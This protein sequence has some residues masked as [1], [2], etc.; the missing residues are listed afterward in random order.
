[1]A[2]KIPNVGEVLLLEELRAYL[3]TLTLRLFQNDYT[4]VD[5][6]VI[7][8][9]TEATFD[10]YASQSLSDFAAAYLNASNKAEVDASLYIF[11][12]TGAVTP[13]T[14]YGYYVTIG[15]TQV[16][17][18]ERNPAGGQAMTGAGQIYP[19]YPRF[20]LASEA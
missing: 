12:M 2:I 7:G 8:N 14:I 10:G 11:L 1:V 18:A 19:V 9:F 3:N 15:G 5:G 6:S 16:V 4:P 20:T 17:Y 13:N